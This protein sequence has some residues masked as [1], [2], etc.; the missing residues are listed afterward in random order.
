MR[1]KLCVLAAAFALAA[2]TAG[3]A[4]NWPQWR[5]PFLN[6]TSDER[7]LP[8]RWSPGEN[9]AWKLALPDRSGS[10]P[11][12]W[13]NHVFLNVAEGDD[14]FLWA[15]DKRQ[16]AVLWKRRLG[17]GNTRMRKHN[18]SSPSPVT[19][20]R[21]VW[22]MTGTGVL[23]A[24]DFAGREVWTRDIQKDYGQFGLM[25]GYASS[26]LL[27]EDSLYVQVLHGMKT[28]DPSYV[29][30]INKATGKTVWRVERPTDAI[31]ESPD[32]YTT[33]ALLRHGKATEI[34]ITGGDVVTGHDLATG[35]EL[36]RAKGLNPENAPFYRIVASPIVHDGVIY[37][38]TR[39]KPLLAFRPGGRGDV[40]TSHLLWSTVNGPDVPTPVTDGKYFYIVNDKGIVYC[41]D[42][43][44][45]KEVYGQQRLKPGTYSASP[46]LADG[47]IYVTNE[48][49][50][51][52]VFKAGPQFEILAENAINEY[53]LSS[54]AV[55]DGQ[56]F[57]RT[58]NALYA[59]GKRAGR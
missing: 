4:G 35:K 2:P 44:T 39:V 41:L 56:L 25:W 17:G 45:G 51:T 40:T 37:A 53:C 27:H 59:I 58:A 49:G 52:S 21:H 26:P 43:K 9:V 22:I 5:G 48:D 15:A 47:K 34:V 11:I 54:I 46:V 50:L 19:D 42:A 30:R 57:L 29:L 20:G 3:L 24:F 55:S 28:D 8:L 36:W 12:I 38:P 7:N 18:M 10:T 33:P 14:L 13:G 31:Q 32:S 16:G 6:G 23:K 1:G